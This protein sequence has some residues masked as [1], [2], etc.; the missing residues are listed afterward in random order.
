[1]LASMDLVALDNDNQI[2]CLTFGALISAVYP[3]A[4]LSILGQLTFSNSVLD[5]LYLWVRKILPN[6]YWY[7]H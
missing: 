4:T 3:V 2:K 6:R 1:M 5:E 7:L